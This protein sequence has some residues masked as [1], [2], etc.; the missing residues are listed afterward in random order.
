[1]DKTKKQGV[2]FHHLANQY[3]E[4]GRRKIGIRKE[5]RVGLKRST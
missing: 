2:K 1:M 4:G 5:E 3:T